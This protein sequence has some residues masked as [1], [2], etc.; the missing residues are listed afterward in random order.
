MNIGDKIKSLRKTKKLTQEQLAEYLHISSQAVS[1]W[2]TG[3]SSPDIDTLPK[4]AAFFQVTIDDLL[5]FDRQRIEQEVN[6][7]VEASVPLR[8]NPEKAEAFYRE[9]LKKYPNNEV[10]LNCLLMVIP[11]DRSQ[12]KIKIGERLLDCTTDDE[13]KYDALRLMVQT[14]HSIG[15][16]AMAEHY[17]AKMPELYFLKTAIAASIKN[18][19]EQLAEIRK[20]EDVC[21]RTL[22]TMLVLR[23]QNETSDSGKDAYRSFAHALLDLY[24]DFDD[25]KEHTARLKGILDNGTIPD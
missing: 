7:L 6:T 24:R 10:L 14:Y 25:Q 9:A 17:L 22:T 4:L 21:L 15:E 3:V 23:I 12:E 1:K 11:D 2:E 18:G 16:N 8:A 13:I 20:T 19:A 5:D